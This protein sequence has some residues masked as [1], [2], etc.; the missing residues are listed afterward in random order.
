M[1][2]DSQ[3]RYGK[4]LERIAELNQK[5]A[6]PARGVRPG[7]GKRYL[8]RHVV[9][10]Q[11]GLSVNDILDRSVAGTFPAPDYHA[12]VGYLAWRVGDIEAW[13]ASRRLAREKVGHEKK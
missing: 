10:E 8:G 1:N 6:F 11:T 12:G 5:E 4:L 9:A 3:H 7:S 2:L 13:L